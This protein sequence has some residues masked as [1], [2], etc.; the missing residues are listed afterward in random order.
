[1]SNEE[2]SDYGPPSSDEELSSDDKK[3]K[4]KHERKRKRPDDD[5]P[6]VKRRKTASKQ[7]TIDSSGKLF[8]LFTLRYIN[9]LLEPM[10]VE[11]Q[12]VIPRKPVRKRSSYPLNQKVFKLYPFI[13]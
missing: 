8:I 4:S 3:P 13:S 12:T 6:A 10:D 1:M 9:K 11:P 7:T 5:N 2:D